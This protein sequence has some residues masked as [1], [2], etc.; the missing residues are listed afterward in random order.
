MNAVVGF[1]HLL[2]ATSLTEEQR[3]YLNLIEQG[4]RSL[5]VI[6]DEV[7]D[8][9]KITSGRLELEE[10]PCLVA[11]LV[12]HACSMLLPQAQK[13]GIALQW[14]LDTRAPA[15]VLGDSVRLGQI[16][17]NLIG[18]A[19]KFTENGSIDVRI[20]SREGATPG[21]CLLE[22]TV[23]DTG[24]GIAPEALDR[25]FRPFSQADNSITRKFGGT[26][27]GLAI[28]KRL[29]ELMHGDLG[30]ESVP[31][32]GATFTARVEVG[33]APADDPVSTPAAKSQ[34]ASASGDRSLRLLV[35]EDNRLNQRVL[36]ALLS[37]L[38]H[39][40]R[41]VG[42]GQ[43]GLAVVSQEKFDAILMDIEMPGIDGYETV[44]QLRKAE[45]VEAPRNYVI[46]VTAHAMKG[47]REKCLAVGMDDFMTKP[48][49]PRMLREALQRC[50]QR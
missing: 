46:A 15:Q 12:S 49:D 34:A 6:I 7:L 8:Y 40:A 39:R 43:E 2:Q 10:A 31:G 42:T 35:F 21:R 33:V 48:I 36:Q 30:V 41:F 24:M 20:A 47:I 11:E 50:P 19:I 3:E 37:K 13:K 45:P 1:T 16:L 4:G 38:G 32:Q 28:S 23:K 27:L 14:T 22:F 17:S 44:R 25:I 5:L 26:G 9:S 18:N 29:C